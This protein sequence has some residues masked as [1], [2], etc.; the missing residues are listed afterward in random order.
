MGLLIPPDEYNL[1]N[2]PHVKQWLENM[3]SRKSVKDAMESVS[4]T[5]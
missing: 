5:G 2:Y 3:S 1:N 4:L